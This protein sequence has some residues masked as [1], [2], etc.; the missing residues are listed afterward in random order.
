MVAVGLVILNQ[1]RQ[2]FA[3]R[4]FGDKLGREFGTQWRARWTQGWQDLRLLG[5]RVWPT[6]WPA[7]WPGLRLSVVV[8]L[9]L[10]CW[11]LGAGPAQASLTDD[12]YDGEI[13]AL[14][15]GN[16]S[17][18]PPKVTLAEALKRD[19]PTILVYYLDDS[20]DCKQFATVVSG[21]Q[22]FYGKAADI[23]AV[24]VDS[25]EPK[26]K[27]EPTDPG[28]YYQGVV[29]QTVIFDKTGKVVQNT[30]GVVPLETLD[31]KLRE[32]FDLLPRE[33]S[34]EL[35]RRMVNEITTELTR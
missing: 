9:V 24:R 5:S 28:Y 17:L 32:V 16:G 11:T 29:P 13:F 23:L 3:L 22:A 26:L 21:L 30:L 19:R 7:V 4:P 20:S 1:M 14:Y 25:I 8:A 31:D 27:Y 15:A 10:C 35:K 18:I 34:V 6:T 33:Q 12:R 2:G